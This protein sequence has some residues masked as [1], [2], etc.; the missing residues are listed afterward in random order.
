MPIRWGIRSVQHALYWKNGG[1]PPASSLPTRA[2]YVIS[3]SMKKSNG[4]NISLIGFKAL[5]ST[6]FLGAFND[7]A[8]KLL[9]AFYLKSLVESPEEKALIVSV[10]YSALILPFVI[11]SP[12]AGYLS[13][14]YSKRTVI[15]KSKMAE[16]GVM[17]FGMFAFFTG[18]IY[19]LVSAVFL[20][21]LQSTFFSPGKYGI[22]PEIVRED[23]MSRA[24]GSL[25]MFSFLAII[26]GTAAGGGIKAI[27]EGRLDL[28][29]LSSIFFI[30]IAALG[31]VTSAYVAKVK[32]AKSDKKLEVNPFKSSYNTYS[33]IKQDK[34]LIYAIIAITYFWFLG[35]V[36]QQNILLY[37]E[38][39]MGI[40]DT[41]TS[42][43]LV[44]LS[45]GIAAGAFFAGKLSGDKIEFGLIPLASIGLTIFT[46]DLA[47][48]Y[49]SFTRTALDMTMIGLFAGFYIV[50]V[51]AY[52]QSESAAADKGE[53]I[54]FS[55]QIS[56]A[57]ILGASGVVYILSNS[58]GVKPPGIFLVLSI[59][60]L[61]MNALIFKAMPLFTQRFIFWGITHS[62]AR[63][64]VIGNSHLS[65]KGGALI[66][67]NQVSSIDS[68]LIAAVAHREIKLFVP[69]RD[70]DRA[71]LK[72]FFKI[73]G[74]VPVP[75]TYRGSGQEKSF[76]K[77]RQEL[78]SGN[79]V[80]VFP[81]GAVTR[82]GNIQKFKE[83]FCKLAQE[84]NTPIIPTHIDKEYNILFGVWKYLTPQRYTISFGKAL[85]P[86]SSGFD[87]RNAVSLLSSHAFKNR[88]PKNPLLHL[89]F[90]HTAKSN[91]FKKFMSDSMGFNLTYGKALAGS[92]TFSGKL[93]ENLDDNESM[94]GI[95]MPTSCI[96][97]LLNLSVMMS[98]RV[99]V[100]LNYTAPV[101]SI[102]SAVKQ[103][104]IKTVI[105]SE[106]FLSKI[107]MEKTDKMLFVEDIFKDIE[108]KNKLK[109]FFKA[110]ITPRCLLKKRYRHKKN[111]SDTATII[112]SSGST[113]E[114]KGVVLSHANIRSN[115]EAVLQ[116]LP[117]SR[118]DCFCGFLPFFH[119]FGFMATLMLPAAFGY[120][121]T[122]HPNPIDATVVGKTC[123]KNRCTVLLTTPTFLS[124]YTKKCTKENFKSLRIVIL[125]AEKLKENVAHAFYKKFKLFPVEG[126][127]C[128]ELS[129]AVAINR[130]DIS[131]A[132][133]KA[134]KGSDFGSVGRPLPGVSVCVR[135]VESGHDLGVDEEG[136][137]YATGP[138]V[139]HGYLNQPEKTAEV[140]VDG[141]YNTGDIGMI[142]ENGRIRVTD[143]LSRFS[144]IAGEM[145]PH[146]G[147][148]NAIYRALQA[149]AVVCAVTSVPDSKKGE[150][151]VVLYTDLGVTVD[152]LWGRLNDTE[153]PKLWIPKKDSFKQI[154][155]M[156]LLGSGKIALKELK[157]IALEFFQP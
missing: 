7:N 13:D 90:I 118:N 22:I 69:K 26:L 138:N 128:T 99:P 124:N 46:F 59:F 153:L 40:S 84:T 101:S 72:W 112:F 78:E 100:N 36:F 28:I 53:N 58:L 71:S 154:S 141:W 79:I 64:K 16:V 4:S 67:C 123:Q 132:H 136:L 146:L 42:V 104:G 14:R 76:E 17:L 24:N 135:D 83:E 145:V 43:L 143:R 129:P 117:L 111:G 150:R 157:I 27:F 102:D 57:A 63:T 61:A 130:P 19:I 29:Y 62:I 91:F 149:D 92:M 120:R 34:K 1:S 94:V 134:K 77:V 3:I 97:A 30:A 148:E 60:N 152:E 55:N 133:H 5:I 85:A 119:S 32:P 75:L 89:S 20:M 47:F 6:Q 73:A 155:E 144:K 49:A 41:T 110:L 21:G 142:D 107:K 127:G 88:E 140:L 12:Y 8:F 65:R 139:M 51:T 81:E 39:A 70:Y 9:I 10:V 103:C 35:A 50:P 96:G 156:P 116:I 86:K 38:I 82:V 93:D 114:P 87:V 126:Y 2:R 18:N 151:L 31:V 95:M 37:G 122:Y 147:V 105:T 121:V 52:L 15:E 106:K 11:F 54:A 109:A 115:V 33:K 56:F 108:T 68:F 113:G 137:L 45:V 74:A 131:S 66:M 23:E 80:C 25:Q 125:G 44:F 98:G 48:S